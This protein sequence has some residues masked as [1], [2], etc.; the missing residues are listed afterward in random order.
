M[1]KSPRCAFETVLTTVLPLMSEFY[2]EEEE[3]DL[4]PRL[5]VIF[6]ILI[7]CLLRS[8]A[9]KYYATP[10]ERY[11]RYFH[12]DQLEDGKD[13]RRHKGLKKRMKDS[14]NDASK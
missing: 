4:P 2:S 6:V 5:I 11:Y 7:I 10:M 8:V 9:H 3:G 1:S 12:L 13:E 14:S